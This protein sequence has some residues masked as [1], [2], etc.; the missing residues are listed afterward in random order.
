[1]KCWCCGQ[2]ITKQ[3][4]ALLKKKRRAFS[5][6]LRAKYKDRPWGRP[7][8]VDREFVSKLRKQGLM[9]REIAAQ[10][11]CSVGTAFKACREKV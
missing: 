6:K 7:R 4:A 10:I 11:G 9:Y 5:K 3:R 1:M 2:N 8:T